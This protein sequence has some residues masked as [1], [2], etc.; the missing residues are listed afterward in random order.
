MSLS[1]ETKPLINLGEPRMSI[2]AAIESREQIFLLLIVYITITY[3]ISS[4]KVLWS[5]DKT[6]GRTTQ[7]TGDR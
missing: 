6:S 3:E 4:K 1:K 7:T 5:S 2:I